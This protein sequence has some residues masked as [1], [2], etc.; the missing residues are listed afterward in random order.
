[1]TVAARE[2]V[3]AASSHGR[4]AYRFIL[5]VGSHSGTVKG[6]SSCTKKFR[7]W[8]VQ[9]DTMSRRSWVEVEAARF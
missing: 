8:R 3:G 9:D 1:M 6:T 4:L 5:S 7:V 2:V